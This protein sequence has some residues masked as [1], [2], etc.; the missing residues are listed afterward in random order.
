[1]LI[2]TVYSMLRNKGRV[3]SSSCEPVLTLQ[4]T[5]RWRRQND[6][7]LNSKTTTPQD[8][9]KDPTRWQVSAAV[10]G[11]MTKAEKDLYANE[12]NLMTTGLKQEIAKSKNTYLILAHAVII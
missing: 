10:S 12:S 4:S 6:R 8:F 7:T 3:P 9:A 1:M 5:P 11:P 2:C